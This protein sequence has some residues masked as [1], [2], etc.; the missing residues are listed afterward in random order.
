MNKEEKL[1]EYKRNWDLANKDKLQ[2][3]SLTQKEKGN[4]DYKAEY[5]AANK[6]MFKEI[7]YKSNKKH[8]EKRKQYLKDYYLK[9]K[10][11]M[12]EQARIYY[13]KKK[14]EGLEEI[15]DEYPCRLNYHIRDIVYML[16]KIKNKDYIFTHPCDFSEDDDE[17][18]LRKINY[19]NNLMEEYVK[20]K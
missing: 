19:F 14:I 3:Y 13:L 12:Y 1:K 7:Q 18:R 10:E 2:Q 4:K 8:K 9:N 6:E 16:E 11:K 5:Y 20:N 17:T 15:I